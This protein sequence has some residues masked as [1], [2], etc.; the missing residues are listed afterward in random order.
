M[1]GIIKFC[2]IILLASTFYSCS[3]KPK[4][5]K[6]KLIESDTVFYHLETK[7]ILTYLVNFNSESLDKS[8]KVFVNAGGQNND[9]EVYL[10]ADSNSIT[11][12]FGLNRCGYSFPCINENNKIKLKWNL[13]NGE[14][15]YKK[16]PFSNFWT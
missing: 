15:D 10:G 8:E 11:L 16:L 3:N 14:C 1:S 12:I 13:E 4:R 7:K 9:G 2:M 6:T 5:L